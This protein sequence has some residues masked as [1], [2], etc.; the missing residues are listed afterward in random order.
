MKHDVINIIF[1]Y[2]KYERSILL[3]KVPQ[4]PTERPIPELGSKAKASILFGW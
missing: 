1:L 2:E 4:S 3:K